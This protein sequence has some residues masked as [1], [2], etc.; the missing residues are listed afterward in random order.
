MKSSSRSILYYDNTCKFCS[1][2]QSLANRIDPEKVNYIPLT[3]DLI[4]SFS[5]KLH[6]NRKIAN[7]VMF[8]R[9]KK[10]EMYLGAKAFFAYLNEKKGLFSIIAIMGSFPP[11]RWFSNKVYYC[12]AINRY[13][14]SK[15]L[16]WV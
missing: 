1:K 6:L 2:A 8:Y 3:N 5:E 13:T 10:G 14:I 11:I 15:F 4:S 9:N 16:F 7:N 12:I